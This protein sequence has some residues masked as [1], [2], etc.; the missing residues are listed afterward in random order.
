MTNLLKHLTKKEKETLFDALNYLKMAEIKTFCQKHSIPVSGKKGEILDRIKQYL[1]T[2]K[3]KL[4][5]KIPEISKA[6]SEKIYP[7]ASDTKILKGSYKND[8]LTRNFFKN[9]IGEHFHFTSFG[10]DWI[11]KQWQAGKPP[12]YAQFAKFWQK[13]YVLRKNSEANPKK[14]W[15]YLNFVKRFQKEHPKL[16]KTDAL[17]A[18]EKIRKEQA[19]KALLILNAIAKGVIR[20][21]N[22]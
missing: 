18:W 3:I 19:K 22:D 11:L 15:A 5:T 21:E 16:Q 1:M 12:T 4:P 17:K 20:V 13:E 6:K 10:Q 7:L 8:T 14:E 9:I 2:G